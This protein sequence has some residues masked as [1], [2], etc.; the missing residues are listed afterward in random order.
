MRNLVNSYVEWIKKGLTLREVSNGWH[1]LVTPFLNHSNDMIELYLK[2]EKDYI[3]I[4]D[5]G[6]TI[7]EL[8]LSGLDIDRSKKRQE[9]LNT[10]LRSFGIS[11][12]ENELYIN[13]DAKK[14]PEVK[15]RFIQAVL[16]IDDLFMLSSPK[17]ETFFIEDVT[18]FF[19]LNDVIF[20]KDTSFTG[21]SGFSHKFDFTLPK[22]KQRKEVAIRAINTPRK[23]NIGSVLWTME[24][25]KLVRP[26]TEGLVI[27]NDQNGVSNDIYQAFRE[28]KIPY[29]VW[30]KRIENLDKLK[31]IA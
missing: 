1:E 9:E 6:N 11:R 16:A 3:V 14:F 23:D 20:V 29:I 17:I 13:T 27:I 10:I 15:H 22:M 26:E 31:L 4:S 19:E 25:T 18:N 28:Y 8:I 12:K 24:D 2:Q 30:S 21:K 5:A 7:N